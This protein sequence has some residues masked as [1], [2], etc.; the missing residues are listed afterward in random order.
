M[1]W[2]RMMAM[3]AIVADSGYI[4]KINRTAFAYWMDVSLRERE[5]SRMTLGRL[6]FGDWENGVLVTYCCATNYPK[7]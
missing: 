2:A 6:W 7:P 3:A 5:K 4:L 1:A